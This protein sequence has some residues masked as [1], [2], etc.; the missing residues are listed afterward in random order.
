M[1]LLIFLEL[2]QY[3]D[4]IASFSCKGSISHINGDTV[5]VLMEN[6]HI[7][8]ERAFATDSELTKELIGA[9]YPGCTHDPLGVVLISE[10]QTCHKCGGSCYC[11]V[12]A[13]VRSHSTRNAWA[14]YQQLITISFAK[15]NA[16]KYG[17]LQLAT[18][19]R[20]ISMFTSCHLIN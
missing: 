9:S 3:W 4:I 19:T 16:G 14:Q 17:C 8:N 2:P 7:I 11:D 20:K 1:L 12:I 18:H 15:I 10:K 5:K 13:T 6:L